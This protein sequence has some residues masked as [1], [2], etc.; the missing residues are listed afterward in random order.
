MEYKGSC[1]CNSVKFTLQTNLDT[2]VQCNCSF[3]KRRNAIMTLEDKN[4]IKI[5]SGYENLSI[6]K[7]NTNIAKHH[8]CKKCGIFVYSNRRFDS[9]GIAVNLGCI[10]DI[11]TFK[12]DTKL[13]DNIHK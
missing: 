13:A 9:N 7:F 6:Y 5:N 12:I 10:D 2:V 1:H 4:S 3:C 11:N 8:F